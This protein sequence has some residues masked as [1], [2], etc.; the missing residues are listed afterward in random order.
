M[1]P[2][3]AVCGHV[4]TARGAE[5]VQWDLAAPN[6]RFKEHDTGYWEDGSVGTRRQSRI[7][8]REKGEQPLRNVSG[9]MLAAAAGGSPAAPQSDDVG[10][11][12]AA[13][14][15][16]KRGCD[17]KFASEG[18]AS[19]STEPQGTAIA[20]MASPLGRLGLGGIPPGA[21]SDVEALQGRLSRK[22]TCVVNAAIMAS[23]WPYKSGM[24]ARRWN[25]PIV[26][27]IDLPI[28]CGE[29]QG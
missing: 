8:L 5:L 4:H 12:Q 27:D 16:P 14:P 3:L 13:T 1:R 18:K 6:V 2:P 28:A 9:G 10:G 25:K 26:V 21:R 15:Y 20:D 24:E 23:S 7:D 17:F 22:E 29:G 19:A 11:Q